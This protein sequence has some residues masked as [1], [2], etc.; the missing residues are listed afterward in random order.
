MLQDLVHRNASVVLLSAQHTPEIKMEVFEVKELGKNLHQVRVRLQNENGLASMT[1]QAFKDKLY[2]LDRLK[3]SGGKVVAGGKIN[4]VRL[5]KVSYK[6]DKPEIQFFAMPGHSKVEYQF[7]IEGKGNVTF[8]FESRKAKN[9]SA[10][11]E[12]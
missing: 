9:V 12:L 1:A 10:T 4:D 5:D 3:V 2:E 6:E 11:V 8:D 7:L